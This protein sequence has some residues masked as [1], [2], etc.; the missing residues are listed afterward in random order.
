MLVLRQPREH[1]GAE[2]LGH[3]NGRPQLGL[4]GV[5]EPQQAAAPIAS[6]DRA[7]D[8]SALFHAQQQRRRRVFELH[9]GSLALPMWL[10]DQTIGGL[11]LFLNGPS[12][13]PYEDL[14][15]LAQAL[16]D[17]ATIAIL[18][19]RAVPRRETFVGQVHGAL[20]NWMIIEHA[21]GVLCNRGTLT[22]TS[23]ARSSPTPSRP[24]ECWSSPAPH[25]SDASR[26][27]LRSVGLPEPN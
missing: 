5:G 19:Q 23:L 22:V 15:L 13:L 4:A 14:R 9:G 20:N 27:Q 12:P 1:V 25:A 11:N 21:K 8:E 18:Q 7:L 3:R 2:R 24:P 17:I 16:A 26:T 10:R 6:V